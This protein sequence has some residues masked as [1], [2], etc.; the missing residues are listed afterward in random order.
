MEELLPGEIAELLAKLRSA[1]TAPEGTT[2]SV[3]WR[4]FGKW[5]DISKRMPAMVGSRG[6]CLKV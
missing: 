4:R 2:D 1:Q 6:R 3:L 5:L